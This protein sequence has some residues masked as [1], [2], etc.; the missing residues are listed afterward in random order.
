MDKATYQYELV[1]ASMF[2]NES[3]YLAEWVSH[4]FEH[5]ADH[6]VLYDNGSTDDG[7]AKVQ[8]WIDS[9]EVTLFDWPQ[10]KTEGAQYNAIH[11]SL[12]LMKQ[13]A[14]W[15]TFLDLD[16]FLFS[17]L[18]V[19][20]PEVLSEFSEEVGIDVHWVCYGSSG[21]IS[22]PSGSVRDNFVRR[23][24]LQFKRNR[25]FKTIINPREAV[26]RIPGNHEWTFQGGRAAVNERRRPLEVP[27]S[28]RDRIER[29]I[30]KI[31]PLAHRWLAVHFPLSFSYFHLIMREVSVEKLRINHYI[32][33]S[34][35]EFMEK[36]VRHGVSRGD[37]YS[38]S[39]FTYHD[40][41]EVLDPILSSRPNQGY[42]R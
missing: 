37:K 34:K 2:K 22:T 35:E 36:Q 27:I 32:V 14:R 9:G 13:R 24:P 8:P 17:P 29:K 6:I 16:E 15:I 41:N 25:Q 28:L 21:H 18:G 7:R 31:F 26:K 40:R 10:L 5:G 12:D 30:R 23:A 19:P 20:L 3:P 42:Q 39:F 1:V 38:Q 33:K 4:H 11:H